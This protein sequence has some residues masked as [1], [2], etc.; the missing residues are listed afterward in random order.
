M[1]R[2]AQDTLAYCGSCKMDLSHTIMAMQGDRVIRVQ[3]RT[4]KKEHT[5][6]AP[7]GVTD[8]MAVKKAAA[9][10]V[11]KFEGYCPTFKGN[12]RYWEVSIA[13]LRNDYNEVQWLLVT[14]R[15]A[16][17]RIELE[18]QVKTQAA[19]I[20]QLRAAANKR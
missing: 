14:S 17:G 11:A 19:E 3:C 6:K 8:P 10:K 16:T 4:C 20:K 1:T 12:L 15:D 18:N 7:K 2:T 5:Y 13:P 9:G